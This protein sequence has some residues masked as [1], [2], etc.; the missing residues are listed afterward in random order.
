[1]KV[2]C[3]NA[4]NRALKQ[5]QI[6]TVLQECICGHMYIIE[7]I[8]EPSV[9]LPVTCEQCGSTHALISNAQFYKSRFIPIDN[10]ETRDAF[11]RLNQLDKVK[12]GVK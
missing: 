9:G 11:E 2:M 6:Y 8:E 12:E 1:M 4:S 7:E 5:F 3:I 10:K